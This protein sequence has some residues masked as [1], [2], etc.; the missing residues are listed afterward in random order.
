MTTVVLLLSRQTTRTIHAQSH[1]LIYCVP[2]FESVSSVC[3]VCL[4]H[5]EPLCKLQL[6]GLCPHSVYFPPE[7]NTS[8]EDEDDES[9]I[10]SRKMSK[11]LNKRKSR[12]ITEK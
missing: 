12:K 9:R 4:K 1:S 6:I 3:N 11:I 5:Y 10:M 8:H 7:V 2:P